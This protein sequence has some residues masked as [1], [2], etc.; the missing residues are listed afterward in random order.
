MLTVAD[1]YSRTIS[2]R[3]VYVNAAGDLG[4]TSSSLRYKE[5]IEDM[6]W[7]GWIYELRPV[8]F[9]F[10]P[11][12]DEYNENSKT[13][14]LIAEEVELVNKNIVDYDEEE[15]VDYVAYDKLIP[16]LL[17]EIQNLNARIT[18]LEAHNGVSNPVELPDKDKVVEDKKPKKIKVIKSE[19]LIE[20]PT[21]KDK[22]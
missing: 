6:P 18:A 14:G 13:Y 19:P 12:Y 16:V 4:T 7:T 10:R 21:P 5:N 15:R 9:D 22:A 8:I 1:I 20:V 2:T 17:K 11:D 3:A